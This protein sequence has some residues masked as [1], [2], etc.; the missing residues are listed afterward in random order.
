MFILL[1]LWIYQ[2]KIGNNF[3]KTHTAIPKTLKIRGIP[4]LLI[5][6]LSEVELFNLKNPLF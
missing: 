3:V 5:L 4:T 1:P 6:Y 2:T